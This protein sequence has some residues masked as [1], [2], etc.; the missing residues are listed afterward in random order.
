MTDYSA[1]P[2][3]PEEFYE[4]DAVMPPLTPEEEEARKAELDAKDNKKKGEKGGKKGKGSKKTEA[5]EFMEGRLVTGPSEIVFE[6][7]KN[8]EKYTKVWDLKD[9]SK[10]FA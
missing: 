8:I 5:D 7:Q 4:K 1:V 9:E 3:L 10:N 2:N 6:M